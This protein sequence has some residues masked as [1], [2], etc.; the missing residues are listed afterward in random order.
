MFL[1]G[2]MT[3]YY[4]LVLSRINEQ[5]GIEIVAVSTAGAGKK[6][7]Q[8]VFETSEGINFPVYLLPETH[9]PVLYVSYRGLTR[10]AWKERPDA[11][12]VP[13]NNF[14]AFMLVPS[15]ALTVRLCRIRLI[16]QSIPFRL[17]KY[18]EARARLRQLPGL[19]DAMPGWIRSLISIT[20]VDV[21]PRLVYLT[22]RKRAFTRASAHLNY[23]DEAREILGSY[24]VPSERIFVTA[25]SPDTDRYKEAEKHIE[26]LPP[27]LPANPYRIIHVGRLVAW[28]RVDLLIEAVSLLRSQF[29]D[30]ELVVVGFG[31]EEVNLKALAEKLGVAQSVRFV[32]GVYETEMLG[33]YFAASSIYVLAGMGGLSI[34]DAM[35]FR[36]PVV[37]SVCDGTERLLVR[38]GHN[39][40]FFEDG[41]VR[42]LA[43]KIAGI[44]R[45]AQLRAAMAQNSR[46]I[47]DEEINIHTVVER[48]V[49]AF[50]RV[51]AP[52]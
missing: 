45:D 52:A 35:F 1:T 2:G 42:D 9:F 16:M 19:I 29:P 37:C 34:N 22:L 47:I 17:L 50:R 36:M 39:G 24:G 7:G 12:V 13:D 44:L 33:R 25:N 28:K 8:A 32:G 6:I 30:L 51:C 11:I 20:R 18:Q 26:R 48:Y 31:P 21:L 49:A 15:L 14:L 23:I 5:P 38:H 4:N 40:Y 46:R 3:H 43:E 10:I 27:L 41:D